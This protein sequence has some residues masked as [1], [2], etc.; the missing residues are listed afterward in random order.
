MCNLDFNKKREHFKTKF[1]IFAPFPWFLPL[2][3]TTWITFLK[4]IDIKSVEHFKTKS[5]IDFFL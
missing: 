4:K 2:L 3:K 5:M 1:L